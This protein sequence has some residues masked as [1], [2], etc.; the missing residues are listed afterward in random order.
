[1]ECADLG[2]YA[3]AENLLLQHARFLLNKREAEEIVNDCDSESSK[4][5]TTLCVPAVFRTG[6]KSHSRSVCIRVSSTKNRLGKLTRSEW[7]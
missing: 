7:S 6:C 3:N 4:N 1:M 5:G 2:R